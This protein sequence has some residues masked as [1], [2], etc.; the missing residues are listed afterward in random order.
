[1]SFDKPASNENVTYK[2]FE[3]ERASEG[4]RQKSRLGQSA[5]LSFS[6]VTTLPLL[7]LT[8]S[9]AGNYQIAAITALALLVPSV[10]FTLLIERF[11]KAEMLAK[12]G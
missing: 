9:L 2:I 1:M 10:V 7:M 4:R 3:I 12:I 11:L 6:D 5:I 8:A